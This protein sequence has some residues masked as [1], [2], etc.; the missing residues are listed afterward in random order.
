MK[1]FEGIQDF[2]VEREGFICELMRKAAEEAKRLQDSQAA[3]KDIENEVIALR[4]ERDDEREINLTAEME[5]CNKIETQK[6][7]IEWVLRLNLKLQEEIK[8]L[9]NPPTDSIFARRSKENTEGS[10]TNPRRIN[11]SKSITF[12]QSFPSNLLKEQSKCD[13]WKELIP[14]NDTA[15]T[16]PFEPQ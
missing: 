16:V 4:K 3:L 8:H 9:K 10:R 11:K 1:H 13:A 14:T 15:E 7:E 12:L 2:L 5:Y 6:A